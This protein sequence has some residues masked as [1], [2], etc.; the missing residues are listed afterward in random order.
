MKRTL[1]V[2]ALIAIAG[3]RDSADSSSERS[4]TADNKAAVN[5]TQ[6]PADNTARNERDRSGTTKTSGDQAE[7][8]AD[9]SI[10]QQIRQGVVGADALSINAKNVKIIT[11]DGVVTL[12]GPVETAGEKDTIAGI[13][14]KVDGVKRV[15]NQLEIAA[16]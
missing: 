16:K 2:V 13:V 15:D 10:T 3:C 6:K 11:E 5:D 8:E 4:E 9:R 1:L 14:K 7:N 12:R